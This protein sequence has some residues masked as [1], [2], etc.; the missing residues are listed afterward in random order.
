MAAGPYQDAALAAAD[1]YGVPRNMFLWQ[2][3]AESGWNP[4]ARN[5]ASSATGIAQ[6][7]KGTAKD[8]GIDPLD[9]LASLDAAAKYD[10]MLYKQTGSWMAALEKYGTLHEAS[11]DKIAGFKNAIG[12][13][14]ASG[15]AGVSGDVE[16][17]GLGPLSSG[18]AMGDFISKYFKSGAFLVLGIVVIAIA[19]LSNKT[20]RTVA[21]KGVA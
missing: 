21:S 18:N 19:A 5:P 7:T 2:I 17:L 1:R 6:F 14:A 10:A 16:D 8:F 20:V 12:Y 9:P 13:D 15:T 11:S 4:T 3:G